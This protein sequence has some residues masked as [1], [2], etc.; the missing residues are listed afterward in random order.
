[1]SVPMFAFLIYTTEA[2][3]KQNEDTNNWLSMVACIRHDNN[4]TMHV[5]PLT[6]IKPTHEKRALRIFRFII[7]QIPMR[8]RLKW[9]EAWPFAWTFLYIRLHVM[10]QQR[11]WVRLREGSHKPLLYAYVISILNSF[12]CCFPFSLS[13]KILIICT[14]PY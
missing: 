1:M 5:K 6:I 4:I 13:R 11:F 2:S 10:E 8:R 9:S 7:L 12:A 3:D 14:F